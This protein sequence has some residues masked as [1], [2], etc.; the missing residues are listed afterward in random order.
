MSEFG[1]K[2]QL[3]QCQNRDIILT[4]CQNKG[5]QVMPRGSAELTSAREN[6]IINACAALYDT[7]GFAEIT[8]KDIGDATS[9]ART[10]IYNYFQTKE[11]IFLAL[12]GREYR[13]WHRELMAALEERGRLTREEFSALLAE[14]LS[15]RER[16]LK[17][18]SM[19]LFA[20]EENS[21][22]EKLVEFKREFGAAMD[23]VNRG[24]CMLLPEMPQTEKTRFLYT[25]FPLMQGV[26][27]YASP[28][29]KQLCAMERAGIGYRRFSVC[30]MVRMA[31]ERL[32]GV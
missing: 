11:E 21:R 27:P 12:L 6:E 19:N 18:L 2:T 28:T 13:V 17:L 7:M 22:T 4:Q 14:T 20:I 8:V 29:E 1:T 31:A 5:V 3:T 15:K 30:D 25:F 10:S 32:L 24:L 16:M 23:A 9:F 26:Y